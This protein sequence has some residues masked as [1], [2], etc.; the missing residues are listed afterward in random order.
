MAFRLSAIAFAA[1]LALPLSATAAVEPMQTFSADY[2]VYFFGFP[3]ARSSFVTRI[4]TDRYDVDGSVES[5]GLAS[6]FYDTTAKTK[7]SGRIDKGQLSPDSYSVDYVYGEKSKKTSLQFANRK[8]VQVSNSPPLPPRRA[9]WVPVGAKELQA[10]LDPLTATLIQAKDLRSVCDHTAKAF[11]GE[12]RADMQLSYVDIAP[13]SIGGYEGDAV[14]CAGRFKPVAG[15]HRGNKSLKYL[16]T[17]SRILVKFAE[18]GKT[19]IYAPIQASVST[20]VG[21]VSIRAR[22]LGASR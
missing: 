21:T 2:S 13:V 6:F 3:V 12:L 1:G 22:R 5:D 11:D 20:R 15:Y 8:V 14:T 10:V 16:S 4:G 18:L 7:V 19:G 9:D 17:K